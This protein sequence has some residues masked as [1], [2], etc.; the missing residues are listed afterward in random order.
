MDKGAT[1][2]IAAASHPV[3]VGLAFERLA[4]APISKI[5]ITD[6]I[7][8]EGRLDPIRDKL[9]TLSVAPLL[10]EAIHRIH[11]DMSVSALF[12]RSAGTKR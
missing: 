2:V 7:P 8:D 3:L 1:D 5:I 10:G 9:V 4:E 12:Q 6:S 11:H